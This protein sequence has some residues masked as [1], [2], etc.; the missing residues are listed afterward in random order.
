MRVVSFMKIDKELQFIYI[1]F[2]M[3][4]AIIWGNAKDNRIYNIQLNRITL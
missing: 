4:Y 3:A 1:H 2:V